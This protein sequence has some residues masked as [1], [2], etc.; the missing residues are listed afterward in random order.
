M[1]FGAH[2][3][4]AGFSGQLVSRHALIEYA[5]TA[6]GLGYDTLCANDHLVFSVPWMDALVALGL[7]AGRTSRVRLMTTAALLAVR[8]A[9]PVG[10]AL[11]ALQHLSGGR[12][13]AAVTPGSSQSDYE[14]AGQ[15]F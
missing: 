15:D 1:R 12:L 4:V 3:P 10:S 8:G 9:S 13:Q 5:E 14:A 6:E 2:L 11:A 7:A